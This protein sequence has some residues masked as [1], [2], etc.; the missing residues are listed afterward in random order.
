MKLMDKTNISVQVYSFLEVPT[1][2][3]DEKPNK[4]RQ[5]CGIHDIKKEHLC[6]TVQLNQPASG[7]MD[8]TIYVPE[9]FKPFPSKVNTQ[10]TQ[11]H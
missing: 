9:I 5:R 2:H 3:Y 11:R 7:T 1:V 8:C 4:E 6:L 10:C